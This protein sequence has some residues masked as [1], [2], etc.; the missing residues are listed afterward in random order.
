MD[1]YWKSRPVSFQHFKYG[2]QIRIENQDNSHSWVRISYGTV[3]YVIDSIQDNTEIPADPKEE[4][5]SQTST[6]VVAA[7]QK[8]NL[9]RENS[10]GRQQ[11]YQYMKEDG[12]TLSHQNKIL[13]RTISRR[14]SLI[15][16]DTI[17]RYSEK[18]MEHL[19]STRQ[20]FI[21]EIIIHKYIIG[22]MIDGKLVW[23]QE[24]DRNE[25]I[26]III[27]LRALQGHS[28]N[29]LIDPMLQD[30]VVVGTGIFPYI[31]H[32]DVRSICILLSTMDWYLEV[33]F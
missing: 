13:P 30:N 26:S 20:N 31:Y 1:L 18:K 14:K 27:Y 10:L 4:Q 23:L 25:D 8:Q 22:L 5:V 6:S 9:N 19:N 33:K 11:P 15:F 32:M 21:F 3:K 24:E 7:R 16:F 12:L 17:K 29:N 2:I 28:G